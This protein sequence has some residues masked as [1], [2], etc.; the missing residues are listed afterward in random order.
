MRRTLLAGLVAALAVAFSAGCGGAPDSTP[1]QA[2][3]KAD[4]IAQADAI[5]AGAN[6]QIESLGEPANAGELASLTEKAV[7][8]D[9][10]ALASIRAL[11]PPPEIED[12]VARA[13]E[14]SEQQNK[15]A[16]AIADAADKRDQAAVQQLVAELAPLQSEARDIAHEIGLKQCGM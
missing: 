12:Q 15:I 4:W 10:K 13:L 5:C 8:I 9:D 7:L 16:R 2:L 3:T 6:A 1:S 14:L 11:H